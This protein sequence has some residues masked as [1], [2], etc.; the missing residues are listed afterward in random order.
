MGNDQT[1][2][3]EQLSEASSVRS[4]PVDTNNLSPSDMTDLTGPTKCC[5]LMTCTKGGQ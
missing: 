1:I 4:V 3:D 5:T 2:Q